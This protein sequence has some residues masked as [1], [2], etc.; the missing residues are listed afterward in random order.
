MSG[1][2]GRDKFIDIF[3]PERQHS[4]LRRPSIRPSVVIKLHE[5]NLKLAKHTNVPREWCDA[6]IT[7]PADRGRAILLRSVGR[8]A[9]DA[10]RRWRGSERADFTNFTARF[11]SRVAAS[12]SAALLLRRGITIK[13]AGVNP[14]RVPYRPKVLIPVK[15]KWRL[16]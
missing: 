14:A 8:R 6:S 4:S 9:D 16:V 13:V 12:K 10:T 15:F 3:H 1:R 5:R 11:R 7:R 2:V